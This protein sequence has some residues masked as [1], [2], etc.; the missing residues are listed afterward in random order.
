MLTPEVSPVIGSE[1]SRR[2]Q[3]R[4]YD[5]DAA[6]LGLILAILLFPLRFVASQILI[7]TIPIVLGIACLLYLLAARS[8]HQTTAGL[9]VLPTTVVRIAPS[10]VMVGV[11]V[12]AVLASMTGGRGF[13][14]YDI[15]A[16]LTSLVLAQVLFAR[17]EDLVPGI[18]LTQ[19]VGLAAVV[20]LAAVFTATTFFGVD[21]WTHMYQLVGGIHAENSLA[22]ISGDKHYAA[23]FYHLF[24]SGGADLM[25][26]SPRHALFLTL[27]LAMPLSVILIYMSARLFVPARWALFA[28]GMYA[29]SDYAIQ[30][31][32]HVIPTSLGLVFFLAFLYVL[33]R[34]LHSDYKTR[35]FFL[36]VLLSVAI[37]LTHQVSS[38][39]MLVLLGAGLVAQGL[40][41]T[42]LFSIPSARSTDTSRIP[43]SVNLSGLMVF[44]L[45]F[46]TF[47]WSLT[48]YRGSN[49]LST[50]LRFFSQ[51]IADSGLF[52]LRSTRD[53]AAADAPEQATTLAGQVASYIDELGFLLLLMLTV[54]GCL[55]VLRRQRASHSGFTLVTAI[56]IMLMFVLG[57]PLFG[58][59]TFI[60]ER[61]FAF[62]Y[63]LMVIMSVIGVRFLA[64][65]VDPTL[66]VAVFVIFILL[67]PS[68]M[69]LSGNGAIDSPAFPSEQSRLGYTEQEMAAA[70]SIGVMTG[71]PDS[72]ELRPDQTMYT[73][74]PYQ[75][76]IGRTGMYD[77][78]ALEP[79]NV[80]PGEPVTHDITVYR[81]AQSTEATYFTDRGHPVNLNVP[82]ERICR[83]DQSTLY[84]NGDVKVCQELKP[85]EQPPSPG[86]EDENGTDGDQG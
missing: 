77:R 39:I 36:L 71:S 49:F 55:Y 33:I 27:G 60:P 15:A 13:V 46:I 76:M 8:D 45:G 47:M 56:V 35:D 6:K 65:Q 31:G 52:Q 38:F 40:L 86:A 72:S 44:N 70:E 50:I 74:Q 67:F 37:I 1:V 41:S 4:R 26:V 20:R 84:D 69:L 58:V 80:T 21:I 30:W 7:N 25:E 83:P 51:S 62:L 42:G 22:A 28:A 32:I 66:F 17:N 63:A 3:N 29:V 81:T 11:G 61:W 57:M 9:P 2:L 78:D 68:V 73:D 12:L 16:L 85:G 59:N 43:D 24:V 23:P 48:P 82:E 64:R 14:F 54:I 19:I 53:T 34:V 79:A 5:V 75:T 10:I 18:V